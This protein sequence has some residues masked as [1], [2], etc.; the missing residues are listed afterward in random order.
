MKHPIFYIDMFSI[1]LYVALYF[2]LIVLSF[3]AY[4]ESTPWKE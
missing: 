2:A 3:A 4:V 1:C